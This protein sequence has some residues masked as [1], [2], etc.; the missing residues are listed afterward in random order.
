MGDYADEHDDAL[1]E[2]EA[3]KATEAE[4]QGLE[5]RG[6]AAVG[7]RHSEETPSFDLQH[8]RADAKRRTDA[9]RKRLT[10]IANKRAISP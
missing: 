9:A 5:T 1:K 10:D 3:A 2:L 8:R 4:L 7:H 6:Y